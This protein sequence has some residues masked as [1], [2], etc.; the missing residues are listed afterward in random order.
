MPIPAFTPRATIGSIGLA[1]TMHCVQRAGDRDRLTGRP[2]LQ[3]AQKGA[4]L[5]TQGEGSH[6]RVRDRR[7]FQ[8]QNGGGLG[9]FAAGC[10]LPP[11]PLA[12]RG[13]TT[14]GSYRAGLCLPSARPAFFE[15]QARETGAALAC[16]REKAWVPSV[17]SGQRG[18]HASRHAIPAHSGCRFD[19]FGNS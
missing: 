19:L 7:V 17:E 10:Q 9:Q 4:T 13:R 5:N 1:M 16:E 11:V 14:G 8:G 18:T 15:G 2:P 3:P 6:G 12:R